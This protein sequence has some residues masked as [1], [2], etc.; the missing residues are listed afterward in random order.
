[1]VVVVVVDRFGKVVDRFGKVFFFSFVQNERG[2]NR[3][4]SCWNIIY[5]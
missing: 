1:M 5:F 4:F 2:I 3:F